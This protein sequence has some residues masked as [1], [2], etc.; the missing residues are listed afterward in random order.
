MRDE[1]DKKKDL[2]K[3]TDDD[4]LSLL[5]DSS[6]DETEEKKSDTES[7]EPYADNENSEMEDTDEDLLA[8]LDMIS[9]Q[10]EANADKKE[11]KPLDKAENTA[12]YAEKDQPMKEEILSIDD[13][14]PDALPS[15]VSDSLNGDPIK[16]EE[17]PNSANDV[18]GV[19]SDVLSA[20]DTL[21][22]KEEPVNNT[23]L[24]VSQEEDKEESG[25]GKKKGFWQR[26]FG[27]KEKAEKAEQTGNTPVT[28]KN[29][30]KKKEE[31]M[32]KKST[33]DKKKA[34]KEK[35]HKIKNSDGKEKEKVKDKKAKAKVKKN[36]TVKKKPAKKKPAK[37]KST[38]KEA[39]KKV[40]QE[41]AAQ[42]EIVA[43]DGEN[44]VKINK[45]A[46]IFVMTFFILV[47]GF[48]ILGT[49]LY[50][51]SLNIKNADIDFSRGRYTDAYNEIYGLDIR[52]KDS[53]TYQKIMTV[54][55]VNKELNSYN[56]Y[57]DIKMYP[58][59]LDSLLKG[60]ERYD[61]FIK[62]A[63]E[64][65]IKNDMDYVKKQILTELK[66][67]FNIKEEEA[68]ALNSSID[69]TEYSINV[70]NT[71]LEKTN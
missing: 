28:D 66:Q 17:K 14:S 42:T 15:E 70:I 58:Q 30:D 4:I 7:E 63:T 54:M 50:S 51:Y 46:F 27:K 16:K 48:I 49:D 44:D 37:K 18:G 43:E 60:L 29:I 9:A 67:Q 10:D 26:I 71:A 33:A 23:D 64:L 2:N 13:S 11:E 6:K 52:K 25:E 68:I 53:K 19:F 69:Q 32:K 21:Q 3:N 61:R 56:N 62:P 1:F 22:D 40:K 8:L 31:K 35:G 34:K 38:K 39:V 45:L 65:G 47:G 20:L 57:M 59:A 41:S 55:Y 12:D 5:Q 36:K 24:S